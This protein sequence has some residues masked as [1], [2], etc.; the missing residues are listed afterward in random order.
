MGLRIGVYAPVRRCARLDVSLRVAPGAR[1][2]PGGILGSE[3]V[4]ERG[5]GL[6][7]TP[8]GKL[9]VVFE[10]FTDRARRV[11]VLAQ[12]EARLFN[13]GYIGTEHILLG[14]IG[15]GD[16]LAAKLLMSL[17]VSL[18]AARKKVEETVGRSASKPTGSPPFTP[19]AKRV[20][21]LSLRE[22]LQ[23]GHRGIDTE[24]VLLGLARQGEG[25][26]VQVLA[27]LGVSLDQARQR[28]VSLMNEPGYAPGAEGAV[29]AAHF[30]ASALR[31]RIEEDGETDETSSDAVHDAPAMVTPP[32]VVPAIV[33]RDLASRYERLPVHRIRRRADFW[34]LLRV[35][36]EHVEQLGRRCELDETTREVARNWW[37]GEVERHCSA[38]RSRIDRRERSRLH[39]MHRYRAFRSNALS[40]LYW[41]TVGPGGRT[42]FGNRYATIRRYTFR[43]RWRP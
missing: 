35:E 26:A 36:E 39:R 11:L 29:F 40:Q 6:R 3:S 4:T 19:R 37:L 17:G 9:G 22:A 20:L 23:L 28:L 8:A 2:E 16:G 1:L 30:T 33:A 18:E 31:A 14:L 5:E 25:Q 38:A 24:H 10:R 7:R 15:E 34:A 27:G 41:N 32:S 13:H 43:L 12:E 42:W 21:E